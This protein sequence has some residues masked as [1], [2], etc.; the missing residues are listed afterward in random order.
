MAV[1]LLHAYVNPETDVGNPNETGPDEWNAEHNL[2]LD[3]PALLGKPDAGN[4]A[5]VE[6]ALGT[7]L[8]FD[9]A[10][11]NASGGGGG[12]AFTFAA[13][14]PGSPNEGDEWFDSDTGTLYKWIDDGDTAQWVEVGPNPGDNTQTP[15]YF[16]FTGDGSTTVFDL[17]D[18]LPSLTEVDDAKKIFWFENGIWQRPGTDFTVVGTLVT[19]SSAPADNAVIAGILVEGLS[20]YSAAPFDVDD[21]TNIDETARDFL[22]DGVLNTNVGLAVSLSSNDLVV[23]L[24]G[25]D[26]NALS[27]TN[28]VVIPFCDIA[29]GVITQI[30]VTSPIS[31]Q[32]A[33]GGT[34]GFSAATAG[35]LWIVAF[36]DS[37]TVRLAAINCSTASQIHPLA[38]WGVASSTASSSSGD[39]AGVFYTSSG[40]TISSKAFKVLGFIEWDASG[41]ASPTTAWTITNVNRIQIFGPGVHLPG[42]VVQAVYVSGTL[43]VTQTNSSTHVVTNRQLAIT[44]KSAAN[45]VRASAQDLCNSE[46]A[47][48]FIGSS[49]SRGTS[50]ST[51]LFGASGFMGNAAGQQFG[52]IAVEGWDKPNTTSSTTYAVQAKSDAGGNVTYGNI[53]FPGYFE[54]QEL[55]G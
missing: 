15:Q 46:A 42:A 10:V 38:E 4:G 11:L 35:R 32:L 16:S 41:V 40:I 45:L 31:V 24:T 28:P 44:L 1:S 33:A 29:T 23:T 53:V 47:G 55:M 48:R 17:T 8:S 37:G 27:A 6:I 7:N 22:L 26:G 14:P 20:N 3:G 2:K 52:T 5:A 21:L 51:N 25:A 18:S 43:T 50:A 12:I 54:L 30:A 36:N 34:L 19:R 13:T 39:S 9:G 49:L